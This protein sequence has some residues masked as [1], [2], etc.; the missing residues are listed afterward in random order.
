[1]FSVV[2]EKEQT[3]MTANVRT[4]DTHVHG[5]HSIGDIIT[6]FTDLCSSRCRNAEE[7]FS[8]EKAEEKVV[9][10]EK[11]RN[12]KTDNDLIFILM[13]YELCCM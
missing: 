4:R 9:Q 12:R 13:L 10:E 7:M 3:N 8:G 6:K 2:G 11:Q 1:M 5:E